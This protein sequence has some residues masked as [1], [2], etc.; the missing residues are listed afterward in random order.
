MPLT[1]RWENVK[2]CNSFPNL[3]ERLNLVHE[4]ENIKGGH[5]EMGEGVR[6]ETCI[7][8]PFLPFN[9]H[10]NWGFTSL[11]PHFLQIIC[12]I[13]LLTASV[14]HHPWNN[15]VNVYSIREYEKYYIN[16]KVLC[17]CK[18]PLYQCD[19]DHSPTPSCHGHQNWYHAPEE[20]GKKKDT[21]VIVCSSSTKLNSLSHHWVCLSHPSSYWCV[22]PT[23]LWEPVSI[24]LFIKK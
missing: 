20:K 16:C 9:S 21:K 17:K 3:S 19:M 14:L 12:K 13:F 24:N 18:L 15:W 2:V 1:A 5:S 4:D 8:V 6:L 7:W 11:N 22:S 23:S 10:I